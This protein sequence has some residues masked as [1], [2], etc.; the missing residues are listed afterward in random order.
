MVFYRLVAS[1]STVTTTFRRTIEGIHVIA[2]LHDDDTCEIE[3]TDSLSNPVPRDKR[4]AAL[5]GVLA[6]HSAVRAHIWRELQ[7]ELACNT[8][9]DDSGS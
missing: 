6:E 3:I 8:D 4:I 5:R 9:A 7:R 1:K 2:R